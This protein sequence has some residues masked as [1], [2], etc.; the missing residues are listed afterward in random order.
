MDQKELYF[1]DP[2]RENNSTFLKTDRPTRNEFI[3]GDT[4]SPE[5]QGL[6]IEKKSYP[7]QSWSLLESS[8][9]YLLGIDYNWEME[10]VEECGKLGKRQR[11]AKRMRINPRYCVYSTCTLPQGA[12]FSF[13]REES[14][15]LGVMPR[16]QKE[17]CSEQ[18]EALTAKV[19]VWIRD[20]SGSQS[21]HHLAFHVEPG[22]K[23]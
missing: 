8:E 17:E 22:S 4:E 11:I 12:T 14:C 1:V 15:F 19:E 5:G 23:L 2:N 20:C 13:T 9:K 18:I 6:L 3:H 10:K 16:C 21:E 7:N